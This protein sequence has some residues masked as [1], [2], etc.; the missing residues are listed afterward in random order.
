MA[1]SAA[2]APLEKLPLETYVPP[3]KPSLIGLSRTGK[4]PLS[5]YLALEGWRVGNVPLVFEQPVADLRPGHVLVGQDERAAAVGSRSRAW[6]AP[7][8]PRACT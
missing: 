8:M 4:T 5:V 6:C 2:A 1:L 7:A 3:A